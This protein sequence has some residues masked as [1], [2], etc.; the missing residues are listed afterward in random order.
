MLPQIIKSWRTKSTTDISFWRYVTYSI[1]LVLWIT[2]AVVI[3]NGPVAVMN[4]LGLM[5]ALSIL[6]LKIKHG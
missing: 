6:Y 1:G 3:H 2:Y 5:L 4:G